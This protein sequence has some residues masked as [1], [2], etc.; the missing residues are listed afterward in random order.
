MNRLKF[1]LFFGLLDKYKAGN[2]NKTIIL[3]FLFHPKIQK[4]K[5][6]VYEQ[7]IPAKDANGHT[8]KKPKIIHGELRKTSL[9]NKKFSKN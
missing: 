9:N 2:S 8:K 1:R 7:R 5:E 6:H 3:T 4:T